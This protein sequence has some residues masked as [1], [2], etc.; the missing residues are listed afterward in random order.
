MCSE[1]YLAG[2]VQ[3][4]DEEKAKEL[5]GDGGMKQGDERE[6]DVKEGEREKKERGFTTLVFLRFGFGFEGKL[7]DIIG[8]DEA[9]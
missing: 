6:R 5:S 2:E 3:R 8:D 4:E 7:K 1:M 9:E